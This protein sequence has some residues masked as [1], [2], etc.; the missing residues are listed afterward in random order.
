MKL[1][2][3]SPRYFGPNAF[4]IQDLHSGRIRQRWEIEVRGEYH[5]NSGDQ[6]KDLFARLFIPIA[7]GK[8]GVEVRGVIVETYVTDEATRKERHAAET[9]PPITC[10]GDLI[11]SSYYQI[12]QSDK[13]CDI[14][15]SGSLKTAS[16]NRLCDARYTD[17]ASYWFETTAGRN[18]FQNKD[19]SINFRLQGM[20]GFYCWMTNDLVHRQNDAILYGYGGSFKFKNVSLAAN[21]SGFHGYE[22]KGDKPVVFRSKLDFEY[23]KTILSLRYNHGIRDFLYD[24]YSVGLVRC[25]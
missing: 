15:V 20:I 14:S 9:R 22:K 2:V 21:W 10:N 3:Y 25:F 13:W 17:A 11:I 24:T 6:T 12:L 16:G 7:N 5:Y 19:N 4:P 1:L 18:I 23:K 8:A